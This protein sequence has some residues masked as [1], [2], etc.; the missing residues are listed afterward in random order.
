MIKVNKQKVEPILTKTYL[1]VIKNS[2]ETKMFRNLYAKV[3]NKRK[4]ITQNGNLSCAFYVSSILFLFKLIKGIHATVDGSTRD[5]KK[6]GW[7]EIK[8]PKSGCVLVWKKENFADGSPHKHIGFYAGK[9]K[10]ISNNFKYGYPR[11][12]NWKIKKVES[13]LWHPSIK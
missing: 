7:K 5:L 2:V 13:I 6:S 12:H 8:E 1:A 4:D 3:N 9:G 11:E 10:A